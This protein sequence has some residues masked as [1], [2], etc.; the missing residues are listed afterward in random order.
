MTF[1]SRG[2]VPPW[3]NVSRETL[4]RLK[5]FLALV[6]KWQPA[7]NLV[8]GGTLAQAWH[9]HI[10]DSAQLFALCPPGARHWA[11]FGSGGGFPGLVI[12]ILAAELQPDL[13]VTLVESDKRKGAFL[14]QAARQLALKAQLQP[15]RAE[16]LAPL[17][18]DVVSA[19]ALA[20]LSDLCALTQRHMAPHGLAIFPKGAQ[21]EV[22]VAEAG[23]L[24]QFEATLVQSQTDPAGRIVT[25]KTLRHA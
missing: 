16:A 18:A 6:E 4:D 2:E 20:A 10:L 7:I 11:D 12:A 5:A 22:E 14:T 15:Q 13:R 25:M 8:A 19:R 3:L 21:A 24:W 9:R 23:K 17:Q 1:W